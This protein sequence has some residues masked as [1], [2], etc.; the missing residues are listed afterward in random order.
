MNCGIGCRLGSDAALLWLW[1]RPAAVAL[2]R[3][4][5]LGTSICRECRPKKEKKKKENKGTDI[6]TYQLSGRNVNTEWGIDKQQGLTVLLYST[7]KYIQYLVISHSGKKYEKEM[8]ICITES[9][10][11]SRN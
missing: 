11:Y 3:P 8:Y 9:L 4:P 2:I 6:C 10:L 7:G 5:S 1:C